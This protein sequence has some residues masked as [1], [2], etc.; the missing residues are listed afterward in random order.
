M[1]GRW[2]GL[3][4]LSSRFKLTSI[5][6]SGFTRPDN[7]F[8]PVGSDDLVEVLSQDT[9]TFGEHS[10]RLNEVSRWMIRILE[11]EKSSFER[12][13][14]RTYSR[15]NPD[16]ETIEV[17]SSD[18][19][20]DSEFLIMNSKIQHM[21]EKANFEQLSDDQVRTALKA[22]STHGIK[23][24]IDEDSLE[25]MSIWVRGRSTAPFHRRTLKH[26]IKGETTSMAV[27]N[28]LVLVTRPAG[29]PNVQVRLFKDIPIRDVE[30][31]LPNAN[32]SMGIR[33]AVM[34]VG[35]GAGAVW[36]VSAKVLAVG[37][38]AA[39]QL[40]WVIAIPLAGL[41]WKVFTGY[42]RA[43]KD[44]DSN[45]AKHLYFQSLG[46]NRSAIHLMSFMI[47]EEEIKEAV[48]MYAFCLDAEIEG[49]ATTEPEMKSDIERYLHKH[50]EIEVDFDIDDAIETLE[51]LSLWKDRSRLRVDGISVAATK[52][53]LHCQ[54]GLSRDYH[55]GLLGIAE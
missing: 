24:K 48:L 53:E 29:E 11:Q 44:R 5:Y 39:S 35:S 16:R 49:R 13:L 7:R 54:Q 9:E 38:V 50:T 33:D 12:A 51:R 2:F 21:L 34:M 31:L 45:R 32:V 3:G 15:I 55:A 19:P 47:C 22:G 41:F 17:L 4:F 43:I 25:E 42:R 8:I 6:E 52:L 37:L 30:A 1:T 18:P 10:S 14:T 20:A 26:P 40:L 46:S 28:R 23:V 27:F 36:T